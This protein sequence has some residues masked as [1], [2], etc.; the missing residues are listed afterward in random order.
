L[1][2]KII[3]KKALKEFYKKDN[4]GGGD[5]Y[6]TYNTRISKNFKEAVINEVESGE[7]TYTYAF[8]LLGGIKGRT[9][10]KIKEDMINYD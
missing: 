3:R 10:D 8:E 4:N 2:V 1:I 5:F 7:I 9:Y 6:K